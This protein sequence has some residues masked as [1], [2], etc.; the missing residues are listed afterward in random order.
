M[1]QLHSSILANVDDEKLPLLLPETVPS[2]TRSTFWSEKKSTCELT[3]EQ[4][5][6]KMKLVLCPKAIVAMMNFDVTLTC[7]FVRF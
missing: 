2:I 5:L 4:I 6:E 7:L 3:L 1:V